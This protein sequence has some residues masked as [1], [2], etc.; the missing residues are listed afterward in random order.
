MEPKQTLESL[1]TEALA[2]EKPR[3]CVPALEVESWKWVGESASSRTAEQWMA[4]ALSHYYRAFS[5]MGGHSKKSN[6]L[7]LFPYKQYPQGCTF[8]VYLAMWLTA[9]GKARLDMSDAQ[10]EQVCSAAGVEPVS[11]PLMPQGRSYFDLLER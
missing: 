7:S 10:I 8:K 9:I 3:L 1:L 11:S 6:E 5:R 4:H 2:G